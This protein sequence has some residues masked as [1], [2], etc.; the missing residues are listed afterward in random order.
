MKPRIVGSLSDVEALERT[1]IASSEESLRSI[2]AT[3]TQNRGL[4]A[5]AAIK[6]GNAGRDPL[7]SSRRLNLMQTLIQ[8]FS[9]LASIMATRV[10]LVTHPSNAPFLL[11]F[12]G[13]PGPDIVSRDGQVVAETFAATYPDSNRKLT[14]DV[15]KVRGVKARHRYVFFLSPIAAQRATYDGVTVIQLDHEC[16]RGL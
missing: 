1:V 8:S 4:S 2:S 9:Y 5:L 12:G 16:L 3:L 6:F 15:E 10:L 14:K 13:T 11:N 7:D